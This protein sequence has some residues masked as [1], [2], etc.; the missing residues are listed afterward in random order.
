MNATSKMIAA[1]R[2]VRGRFLAGYCMDFILNEIDP[3]KGKARQL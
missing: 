3:G 2:L 1:W